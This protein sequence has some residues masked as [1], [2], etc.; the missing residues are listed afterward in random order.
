VIRSAQFVGRRLLEARLARGLSG[1]A[2]AELL[3]V[4]PSAISQY[5][6][7]R[8]APRPDV[9]E[10]LSRQ[11]NVPPHF[12]FR[13]VLADEP[14]RPM[15][16]RSL[17]LASK[18]GRIQAEQR[19]RWLREIVR[20]V[21]AHLDFPEID[22]PMV[23]LGDDPLAASLDRVEALA[24]EVRAAWRL[25]DGPIEDVLLLLENHGVVV[26][27]TSFG[28]HGL[29][30]FS[31][32]SAADA[33]PYIVIGTDKG[34]FARERYDALHE[35]GHLVMHAGLD[36]RALSA[37]RAHRIVENQAFRFASALALPARPFLS[38]LWAPTLDAFRSL[39][40]RWKVSIGVMIY[41]CAEL[42]VTTPDQT[43]RLWINYG[44]RGWRQ[45]E[46]LDDLPTEEPRLLRRCFDLLISSQ[47]KSRSEILAD[48]ALPAN[49]IERLAGLPSGYFSEG[50]GSMTPLVPKL[51]EAVAEKRTSLIEFSSKRSDRS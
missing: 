28:E 10:Q 23:G 35:C 31:Y 18:S 1:A 13:S 11:L 16:W 41:R 32:W 8:H 40:A 38:D 19:F 21:H 7:E 6:N 49:V 5:E 37:P 36:A 34:S 4:H 51:R 48:I 15:N 3:D 33:L 27:R 30:A 25:G 26:T 43:K 46:P 50:F 24:D 45:N 39:K 20:Y 22:F 29:D 14:G 42:G 2:L 44:R 17:S 9:L 12:F 47:T